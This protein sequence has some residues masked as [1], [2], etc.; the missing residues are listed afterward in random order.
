MFDA[1]DTTGVNQILDRQ[2]LRSI[3]ALP[4]DDEHKSGPVVPT[5]VFEQVPHV[6]ANT[7]RSS[8]VSRPPPDLKRYEQT[9]WKDYPTTVDDASSI[10]FFSMLLAMTE[11]QLQAITPKSAEQALRCKS[12][13]QWKQ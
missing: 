6:A 5:S 12:S 9:P 1:P 7:R 11:T 10:N 13:T 3:G 8:R 2:A 4:G